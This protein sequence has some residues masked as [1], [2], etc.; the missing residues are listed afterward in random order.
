MSPLLKEAD[1]RP[2]FVRIAVFASH[3]SHRIVKDIE[4]L[5]MFQI[6][7]NTSQKS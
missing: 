4:N 1:H 5:L 3:P 2:L 6:P 7:I